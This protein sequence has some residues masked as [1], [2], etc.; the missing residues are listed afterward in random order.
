[1]V[2]SY[3]T[4]QGR[5]Y[6]YYVCLNAQR[7]GWAACPSKSLPATAIEVSVVGRIRQ[8]SPGF[9]GEREWR[10]MERSRQVE[11]IGASVTRIDFDGVTRR[12]TIQFRGDKKHASEERP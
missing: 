5:K 6:P 3:A 11:V 7:K 4:K 1:M 2:Y 10:E 8:A 9:Y 12:I